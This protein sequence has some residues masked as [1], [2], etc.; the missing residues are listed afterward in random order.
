MSRLRVSGVIKGVR[1]I[2]VEVPSEG[3]VCRC[4]TEQDGRIVDV[5]RSFG[6]ELERWVSG[7]DK[8]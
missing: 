5:E 4:A 2:E 3:E 1:T 7:N 6:I 8:V